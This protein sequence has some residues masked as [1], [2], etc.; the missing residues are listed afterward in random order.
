MF[1]LRGHFISAAPGER[2][3]AGKTIVYKVGAFDL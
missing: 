3:E 2:V 1:A